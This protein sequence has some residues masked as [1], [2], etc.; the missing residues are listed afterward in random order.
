M[1]VVRLVRCSG[2][3]ALKLSTTSWRSHLYPAGMMMRRPTQLVR[4]YTNMRRMVHRIVSV[5]LGM[6]YWLGASPGM[7]GLLQ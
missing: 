4:V 2:L 7:S 1:R 5:S 3:R 6:S